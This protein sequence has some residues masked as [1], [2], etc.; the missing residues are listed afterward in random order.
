MT[1]CKAL[2]P[3]VYLHRG[4]V[5]KLFSIIE[6]CGLLSDGAFLLKPS[7]VP[8][9]LAMEGPSSDGCQFPVRQIRQT[10]RM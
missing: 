1:I 9:G 7:E 8:C 6:T 2:A 3:L 10:G 5:F 4:V